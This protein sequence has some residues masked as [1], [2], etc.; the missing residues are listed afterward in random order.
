MKNKSNH[1]NWNKITHA[2]EHINRNNTDDNKNNIKTFSTDP[3]S[4][5]SK[6]LNHDKFFIKLVKSLLIEVSGIINEEYNSRLK[7]RRIL[8]YGLFIY[9]II[10]TIFVG[11]FICF[12]NSQYELKIALI[13]GFFAHLIGLFVIEFKYAFSSS[14]EYS[15]FTVKLFDWV[16]KENSLNYIHNE[17]SNYIG[18]KDRHLIKEDSKLQKKNHLHILIN[19]LRNIL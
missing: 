4:L 3:T 19:D 9:F 8:F 2:Q 14:K 1:K 11:L 18:M 12:S 15:D 13:I 10:A 6:S 5:R 16:H 7:S 17:H